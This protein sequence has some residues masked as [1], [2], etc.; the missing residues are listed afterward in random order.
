MNIDIY[1]IKLFIAMYLSERVVFAESFVET[2][3][4]LS[5]FPLYTYLRIMEL[6]V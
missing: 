5:F 2:F 4:F 6:I 3:F 1:F